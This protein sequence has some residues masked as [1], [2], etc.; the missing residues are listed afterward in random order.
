MA[1]EMER[2]VDWAELDEYLT[3]GAAAPGLNGLSV[4]VLVSD[5]RAAREA[6][7]E[8]HLSLPISVEPELVRWAGLPF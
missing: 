8:K 1:M 2:R 7:G 6:R 3:R 5:T 4:E